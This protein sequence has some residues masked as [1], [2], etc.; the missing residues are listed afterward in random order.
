VDLSMKQ[1]TLA[2]PGPVTGQCRCGAVQLEIEFPARWAWHDHT[3]AS[4]I[5]HGAAYATYVGSWRRRFRV[6]AGEEEITRYNDEETGTTRGFCRR[7]GTPLLYER[8]C[9]PHMVNIPRALFQQRTGREPLYHIGIGELR[10]WA[11]TGAPLVPLKGFPGVVWERP[12]RKKK[13][14]HQPMF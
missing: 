8:A 2:T 9:S 6:T 10:D 7:C 1:K 3:S 5:A 11:W 14:L 4:R 13:R 12:G